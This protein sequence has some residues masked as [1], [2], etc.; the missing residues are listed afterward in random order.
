MKI[1][2]ELFRR[3]PTLATAAQICLI[4]V[5]PCLL[6]MWVDARL[7]NGISVWIK[8]AK[9]FVSLALYYATLAWFFG[10][11]PQ[12]AQAS[13]GGHFVIRAALI[14]GLLEM[15]WLIAAA[16]V[17]VPSHFNRQ[18]LVWGVL[19][20]AAGIAAT[21]LMLAV[22]VQGVMI[23]RDRSV[24]LPPAFRRSLVLGAGLSFAVTLI[25]AAVL[26]S[27]TGHWVG[28][29]PSDAA[30]LPL[31]GWSRTGGDL[32]VA[33]FFALHLHQAL[34]LAG[35]AIV[36]SQLP[37]ALAAVH[38]SA[39]LMVGWVGFTF[40]QALQGRAVLG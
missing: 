18:S 9:F 24:N 36:W 5:L 21:M 30:G 28:G 34:P 33:H 4:A 26:S 29:T 19:Y 22:L 12:A 14:A 11:L 39:V 35:W 31:V 38:L 3:Q 13:R 16:V 2:A 37:R 15:A 32:R 20:P 17:G 6:A 27:G 40:V 23:S 25:T 7:I 10:Y 8:P 1:L